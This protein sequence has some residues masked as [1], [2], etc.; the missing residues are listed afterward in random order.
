MD[1]EALIK[2]LKDE[3]MDG[4]KS[5]ASG[6]YN[7]DTQTLFAE[8]DLA[9]GK[10]QILMD[11]NDYNDIILGK[12]N[13]IVTKDLGVKLDETIAIVEVDGLKPTQRMTVKQ[14]SNIYRGEH[15]QPGYCVMGWK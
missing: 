4:A 13:F 3:M 5:S 6:R 15:M 11:V 9:K 7:S 8:K 1:R 10:K 14:V 12:I 2:G